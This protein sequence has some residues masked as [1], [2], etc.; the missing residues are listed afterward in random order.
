M[1]SMNDRQNEVRAAIQFVKDRYNY[2]EGEIGLMGFSQA[3]W[4]V[5]AVAKNNNDVG[6]I[7][8]VGFAINWMDQGLYMTLTKLRQKDASSQEIQSACKAH[9]DEFDFLKKNPSYN[10]LQERYADE[11]NLMSKER[12]IFVKKNF[13]SDATKDYKGITQPILILLGEKD[14]N[15]NVRN[16]YFSLQRLFNTQQN[17]EIHMIPNATHSLLKH[18]KYST[19]VPGLGFFLNLMWDGEKAYSKI[20]LNHLQRWLEISPLSNTDGTLFNQNLL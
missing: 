20:F 14:L 18:P 8:G 5:P 13:L 17:M 12:F 19:Q 1:Q 6:F 16:T 15:V 4:V 11:D 9:Q 3:G 10:E 7:I 2:K